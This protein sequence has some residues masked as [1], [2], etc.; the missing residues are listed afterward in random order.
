MR[1]TRARTSSAPPLDGFAFPL[2]IGEGRSLSPLWLMQGFPMLL[3]GTATGEEQVN[4]LLQMSVEGASCRATLLPPSRSMR[5]HT[6]RVSR[7]TR[8]GTA[9]LAICGIRRAE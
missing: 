5:P 2:V 9:V 3:D 1:M 4:G 6:V 8:G 7:A